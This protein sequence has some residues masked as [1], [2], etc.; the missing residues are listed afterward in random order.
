MSGPTAVNT[1]RRSTLARVLKNVVTG[2]LKEVSNVRRA[3]FVIVFVVRVRPSTGN[4]HD[5]MRGDRAQ[6]SS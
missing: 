4:E 2:L 1:K 6:R 5:C 3:Y